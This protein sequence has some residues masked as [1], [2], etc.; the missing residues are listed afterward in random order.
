MGPIA[1]PFQGIGLSGQSDAVIASQAIAT[2]RDRKLK[3]CSDEGG[4]LTQNAA[5]M[6]SSL[7]SAGI[8]ARNQDRMQSYIRPLLKPLWLRAMIG[9]RAPRA[10]Q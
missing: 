9:I 1:F 5:Y 4:L 10:N 6:D 7:V 2:K 3:G 8:R